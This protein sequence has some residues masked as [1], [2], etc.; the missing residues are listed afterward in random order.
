MGR[1]VKNWDLLVVLAETQRRGEHQD[2]LI[3][4]R[5]FWVQDKTSLT[6]KSQRKTKLCVHLCDFVVGEK[7]EQIHV[8]IFCPVLNSSC[9]HDNLCRHSTRCLVPSEQKK[10]WFR[11]QA[12]VSVGPR[13]LWKRK[14]PNPTWEFSFLCSPYGNR[15][16]VSGMKILRPNP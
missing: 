12:V 2:F 11:L 6:T 9:Y 4:S 8:F 3:L 16:R 13:N 5:Q 14:K 1:I 15:T 10:M 7:E